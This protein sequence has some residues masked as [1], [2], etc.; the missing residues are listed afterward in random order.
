M[1]VCVC[2]CIYIHGSVLF[3]I[4]GIQWG[5]WNAFLEDKRGW[6]YINCHILSIFMD[7]KDKG[8]KL[9]KQ[10]GREKMIWTKGTKMMPF[11]DDFWRHQ[12][13]RDN[14]GS[15]RVWGEHCDPRR[16][17]Q[18]GY[19]LYVKVREWHFMLSRDSRTISPAYPSWKT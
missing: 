13:L 9:L 17:I 18:S 4:S 10:Q 2:V 19:L 1:C 3:A 14:E 5:S 11:S 12:K 6:L 16:N 8:K 15:Y 7:Y